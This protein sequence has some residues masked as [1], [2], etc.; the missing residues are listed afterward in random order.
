MMGGK[1]HIESTVNKG[2]R[3]EIILNLPNAAGT[4]NIE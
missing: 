2:S 1:L 3:F 4:E